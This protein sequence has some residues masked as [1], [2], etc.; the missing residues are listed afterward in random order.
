MTL[1]PRD[2]ECGVNW[3]ISLHVL[4]LGIH[5]MSRLNDRKSVRDI[6]SIRSSQ[7]VVGQME[8]RR[9]GKMASKPY[10]VMREN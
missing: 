3:T 6:A 1:Y 2:N 5:Q 8:S 7:A 10:Q 4:V 9:D